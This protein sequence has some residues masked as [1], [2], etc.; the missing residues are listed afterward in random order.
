[1]TALFMSGYSIRQKLMEASCCIEGELKVVYVKLQKVIKQKFFKVL[2]KEHTILE[3][4]DI[5]KHR[6]NVI[7]RTISD[8]IS[9]IVILR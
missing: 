3:R 8:V 2:I 6:G 7:I 4:I 5:T 1:M 9:V